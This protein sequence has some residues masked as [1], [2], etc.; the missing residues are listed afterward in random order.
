MNC[1]A[2]SEL[3]DS[4]CFKMFMSQQ[5]VQQK[6]SCFGLIIVLQR[7]DNSLI[8]LDTGKFP[9]V[10]ETESNIRLTYDASNISF[11]ALIASKFA[12]EHSTGN[13]F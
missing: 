2:K 4:I 9:N 11:P 13:L 10:I 1:F 8:K 6:S 12:G 3:N 7:E 5:V